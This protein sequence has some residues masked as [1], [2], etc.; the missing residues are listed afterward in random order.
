[1]VPVDDVEKDR[2]GLRRGDYGSD[3][4]KM[5]HLAE[6]INEDENPSAALSI[7]RQPEDKVHAHGGPRI[8]CNWERSK[9]GLL[10]LRRLD[11]LARFTGAYPLPHPLEHVR[12]VEVS[13]KRRESLL[14]SEVA[15]AGSVMEL[16]NQPSTMR[17]GS[18]RSTLYVNRPPSSWYR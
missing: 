3:R 14:A 5:K 18:A 6:T 15:A 8:R 10:R 4:G 1:M 2:R 9:R 16:V 12:P 13:R 11:A 7:S 17:D